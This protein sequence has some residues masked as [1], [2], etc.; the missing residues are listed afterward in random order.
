MPLKRSPKC[1][2]LTKLISG[3][4]SQRKFQ[5]RL[6]EMCEDHVPPLTN[7]RGVELCKPPRVF[8]GKSWLFYDNRTIPYYYTRN[9]CEQTKQEIAL[10]ISG[11]HFYVQHENLEVLHDL[12][13]QQSCADTKDWVFLNYFTKIFY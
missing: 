7:L 3:E 12:H 11:N 8:L 4:F 2:Q 5:V 10:F 9:Q 6:R 13:V 1:N